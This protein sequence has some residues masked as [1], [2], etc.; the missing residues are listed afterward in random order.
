MAE[1]DKTR[2][3]SYRAPK[4][5]A[6]AAR[7]REAVVRAA[8]QDFEERS[9]AG[10]TVSG[11]AT[12]AGVSQKTVEAVFGTKAAL[13]RAAVD[14]AIRG[15][16]DPLPMPQRERV[17]RMETAPD[18][19]TML[20]LHAAHLRE[21]NERS[22]RI[23][24]TVENAAGADA[25]VARLWDEMNRNRTYAVRWATETLLAKPGRRRGLRRRDVEAVFWVA[26]DWSTYRT[27][28]QHAGRTA[29]E[30]ERWFRGYYAA[31][32]LP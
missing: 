15:D 10:T 20:R 22:A 30:V 5:E 24:A 13:L 2:T 1:R 16:L 8:K 25:G 27:L 14:Y 18:A 3:R 4:R 26:I 12:A 28:T 6:A 29:D 19:E 11:V 23:A 7:T 17:R 9:W 21:I 31:T 32:L